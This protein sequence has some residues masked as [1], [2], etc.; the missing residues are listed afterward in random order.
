MSQQRVGPNLPFPEQ[1]GLTQAKTAGP[2][3]PIHVGEAGFDQNTIL[4]MLL[5]RVQVESI[6]RPAAKFR[7]LTMTDVSPMD[8][9][10]IPKDRSGFWV[11][12]S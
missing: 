3:N 7:A 1:M 12:Q 8:P 4:G 10:P 9:D 2:L 11:S 6:W 5:I